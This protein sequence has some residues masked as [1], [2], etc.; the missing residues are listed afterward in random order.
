MPKATWRR[1]VMIELEELGLT[2]NEAQAESQDRVEWR[3]LIVALCPVLKSLQDLITYN[4][5]T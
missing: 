3:R 5:E 2:W 1:T 4:K